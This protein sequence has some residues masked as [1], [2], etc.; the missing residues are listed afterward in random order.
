MQKCLSTICSIY[1]C[2]LSH[3]ENNWFIFIML[4]LLVN[5]L[6][7]CGIVVCTLCA[8]I[9]CGAHTQKSGSIMGSID[10]ESRSIFALSPRFL[11]ST[12]SVQIFTTVG[13]S[14]LTFMGE[15]WGGD[16][17]SRFLPCWQVNN[18]LDGVSFSLPT[19]TF[20]YYLYKDVKECMQRKII[21]YATKN[22]HSGYWKFCYIEVSSHR[23]K[24][25][26]F[27]Y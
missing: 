26:V 11:Q 13:K 15:A 20:I 1:T 9:D 27:M 7:I 10:S 19:R 5:I 21:L 23:V 24:V 25:S 14:S 2:I 4:C 8:T 3:L 18:P 16:M 22:Y 17:S 6:Q 12:A